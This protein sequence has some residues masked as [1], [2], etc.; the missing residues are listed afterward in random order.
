LRTVERLDYET[1]AILTQEIKQESGCKGKRLY[2]P[3]RVALTASASGLDL[4][5]FIPLVEEGA[6][7]GFPRPLKS[8][9]QRIAETAAHLNIA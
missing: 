2:K 9:A 1:Y 8:C 5:K 4:D 3:L 7:L 6:R